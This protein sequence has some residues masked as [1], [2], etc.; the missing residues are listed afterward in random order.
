MSLRRYFNKSNGC[1]GRRLHAQRDMS[2]LIVLTNGAKGPIMP[3][4]SYVNAPHIPKLQSTSGA[5]SQ[6]FPSC[7]IRDFAVT[8]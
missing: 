5:G 1:S 3:P 8:L 6:D 2:K 4:V 7:A